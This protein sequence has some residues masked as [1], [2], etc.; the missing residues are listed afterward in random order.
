MRFVE[1]NKRNRK[2]GKMGAPHLVLD[3]KSLLFCKSSTFFQF[4]FILL[5][6]VVSASSGTVCNGSGGYSQE[7]SVCQLCVAGKYNNQVAIS[8]ENM[9]CTPCLPD[10]FAPFNGTIECMDCGQDMHC[11]GGGCAVCV[12]KHK[13]IIFSCEDTYSVRNAFDRFKTFI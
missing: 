7:N 6:C 11:P 13:S 1:P 2:G 12:P 5:C 9:S 4:T 10:E 8:T 3:S